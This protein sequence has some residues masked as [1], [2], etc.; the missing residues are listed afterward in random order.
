MLGVER[1]VVEPVVG[2]EQAVETAGAQIATRWG[3]HN[4]YKI[5]KPYF[6]VDVRFGNIID[7]SVQSSL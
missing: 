3:F 1:V 5:G 2:G 7:S 6:A 4:K